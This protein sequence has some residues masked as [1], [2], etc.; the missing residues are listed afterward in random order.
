M[1]RVAKRIRRHQMAT[2]AHFGLEKGLDHGQR[3]RGARR[4]H[5]APLLNWYAG[6]RRQFG[7]NI[8]GPARQAPAVA[9]L[10]PRDGYES[11]IADRGAVGARVPLDQRRPLA[12][13]G[14]SPG[15][16]KTHDAAADHCKVK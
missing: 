16:G 4:Q 6:R 2:L 3:S 13:A 12:D 5:Q 8:A 15:M 14:R 10:L 11:K 9:A 1:R 7:P